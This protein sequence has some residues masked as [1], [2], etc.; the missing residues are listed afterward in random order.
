MSSKDPSWPPPF[1]GAPDLA[2]E[3][4]RCIDRTREAFQLPLPTDSS[5]I[6][7]ILEARPNPT[8]HARLNGLKRR[9]DFSSILD[10]L[11]KGTG[12]GPSAETCRD[13]LKED[14]QAL[15]TEA[16]AA[17]LP[18]V[19]P[20]SRALLLLNQVERYDK[21]IHPLLHTLIGQFGMGTPN[22]PVPV[23]FCYALGTPV[24][25]LFTE[26]SEVIGT[27]AL[28][29]KPFSST[30]DEDLLAYEQVLLFPDEADQFCAEFMRTKLNANIQGKVASFAINHR[31]VA[32]VK[33]SWIDTFSLLIEGIP[34]KMKEKQMHVTA[35]GAYRAGFLVLGDDEFRLLKL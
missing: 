33:D 17:N 32:S 15:I 3:M 26:A 9:S 23:V 5:V 31:A 27:R 21:A 8:L 6:A 35:I 2:I 10:Q 14:F 1:G 7:R 13:A 24:D 19:G 16:R 25:A 20:E 30:N 12:D 11:P 29:L 18:F 22:E 28:E 34:G 4:L